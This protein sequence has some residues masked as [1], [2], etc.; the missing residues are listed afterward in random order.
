MFNKRLASKIV[1]GVVLGMALAVA[2]VFAHGSTTKLRPNSL[3]VEQTYT[4]PNVYLFAVPIDGQVIEEHFT[5]I[6]FQ[7]YGT[8]ELYDESVLFCGD[9]TAVFSSKSGPMVVTYERVAHHMFRGVACHDIV[10]AV[11]EVHDS[12]VKP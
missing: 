7:P 9:V 10:G 4:N 2:C 11:F 6:R 3:G 5:S 12:P 1:L 8:M